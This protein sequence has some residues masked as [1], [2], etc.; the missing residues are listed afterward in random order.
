MPLSEQRLEVSNAFATKLDLSSIV[1]IRSRRTRNLPPRRRRE[2]HIAAH[3]RTET[4]SG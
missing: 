4:R 1:L 3:C 2:S